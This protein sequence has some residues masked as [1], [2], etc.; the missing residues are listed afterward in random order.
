MGVGSLGNGNM[1]NGG[2]RRGMM[3]IESVGMRKGV[4][5][6]VKQ[7]GCLNVFG[8]FRAVGDWSPTTLNTSH[9]TVAGVGVSMGMREGSI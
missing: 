3:R 4:H 6:S 9:F 5:G 8:A 1:G 7:G 2:L